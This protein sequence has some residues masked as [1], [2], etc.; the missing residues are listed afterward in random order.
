MPVFVSEEREI[1]VTDERGT[2]KEA[3]I[4]GQALLIRLTI[5]QLHPSIEPRLQI[6]LLVL[7]RITCC[8]PVQAAEEGKKSFCCNL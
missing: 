6:G 2:N 8:A 4:D 5:A 7:V 1:T 3:N